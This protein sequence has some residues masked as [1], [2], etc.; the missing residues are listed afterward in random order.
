MKNCQK[1]NSKNIKK[2]GPFAREIK[3]GQQQP[4]ILLDQM[5]NY[6]CEDC[7]NEWKIKFDEDNKI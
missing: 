6:R 7:G 5:V 4:Q 2:T 3:D 1:C